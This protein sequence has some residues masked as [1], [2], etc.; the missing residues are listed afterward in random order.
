MKALSLRQ[1]WLWAVLELG[2]TIEN[3]RWNTKYR[4]PILLHAAKGC[5]VVECVGA[6]AWMV[7][8]NL[9]EPHDPRWPGLESVERGGICGYAE[10]VDV[11]PP[12]I[13]PMFTTTTKDELQWH[14]PEQYGFVLGNVR[15]LPF[16]P[17]RGALG[18]FEIPD[19]HEM[20]DVPEVLVQRDQEQATNRSEANE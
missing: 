20:F 13:R 8:T 2:K 4:G 18:L 15:R 10:I 17:C 5:T 6:L 9:L 1:P 11:V 14:M 19:A 7:E 12:G 16:T 3:R